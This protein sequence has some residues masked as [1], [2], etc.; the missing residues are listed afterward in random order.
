VSGYFNLFNEIGRFKGEVLADEE[1]P[2]ADYLLWVQA[3]GD[4]T[5]KFSP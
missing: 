2:A 1:M 4:W 5:L 3:D